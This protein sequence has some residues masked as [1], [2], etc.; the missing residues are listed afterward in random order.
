MVA[1]PTCSPC[2]FNRF[3]MASTERCSSEVRTAWATRSRCRVTGRWRSWRWRRKR[4]RRAA[5]SPLPSRA[6]GRR[7]DPLVQG[8]RHGRMLVVGPLVHLVE[9]LGQRV[10][11][12]AAYFFHG[13]LE[14]APL[15]ALGHALGGRGG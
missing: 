6:I 12:A 14:L 13:R 3:S 11:G 4:S 9:Q 5:P 7:R 1:V 15:L 2:S 8:D 10:H